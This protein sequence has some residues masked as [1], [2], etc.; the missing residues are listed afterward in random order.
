MDGSTP[1]H[2]ETAFNEEKVPNVQPPHGQYNWKTLMEKLKDKKFI[3][4]TTK[5]KIVDE[6]RKLKLP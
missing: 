1:K 3:T 5:E 2:Y 6:V 4:A